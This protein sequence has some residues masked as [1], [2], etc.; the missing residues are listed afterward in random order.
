MGKGNSLV[1]FEAKQVSYPAAAT[2]PYS[3]KLVGAVV[4]RQLDV[5]SFIAAP[6]TNAWVYFSGKTPQFY[7]DNGIDVY[8]HWTASTAAADDVI[9]GVAF[10]QVTSLIITGDSFDTARTVTDTGDVT[11]SDKLQVCTISFT[12]A[13]IDSLSKGASFRMKVYRATADAVEDH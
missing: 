8:I 10:E 2:A 13:E 9:W 1:C 12:N 3:S 5:I 4:I 11:G 6:A 7:S